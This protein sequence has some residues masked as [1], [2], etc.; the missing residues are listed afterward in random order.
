MS[1]NI[2]V[3]TSAYTVDYDVVIRDSDGLRVESHTCGSVV[4]NTRTIKAWIVD[5][6][7]AQGIKINASDIMIKGM[8]KKVNV[9]SYKIMASNA[10]IVA[11]CMAQGLEVVVSDGTD[12]DSD[13]TEETE[14]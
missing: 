9:K 2:N 10:D 14:N 3:K 1:K 11:A 4:K 12:T 6:F 8:T 5:D 7:D 13:E